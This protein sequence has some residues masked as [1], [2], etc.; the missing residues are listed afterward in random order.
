[1]HARVRAAAQ[2][3]DEDVVYRQQQQLGEPEWSAYRRAVSE[4]SYCLSDTYLEQR[5]LK[6]ARWHLAR[7]NRAR[8]FLGEV[9]TLDAAS[10]AGVPGLSGPGLGGAGLAIPIGTPNDWDVTSAR[11]DGTPGKDSARAEKSTPRSSSPRPAMAFG[12]RR[13]P[14]QPHERRTS[15]GDKGGGDKGGGD[16]DSA[17]GTG[18]READA[19][20]NKGFFSNIAGSMSTSGRESPSRRGSEPLKPSLTPHGV[21]FEHS[22]AEGE[23]RCAAALQTL[24]CSPV[25]LSLARALSHVC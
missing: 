6:A 21:Y 8:A 14:H 9:A 5:L 10:Q 1:M 15:G 23:V 20:N 4:R 3:L 12:Q 24:L 16:K 11:G 2:A 19:S 25:R 18:T 13:D 22:T 7:R 17:R